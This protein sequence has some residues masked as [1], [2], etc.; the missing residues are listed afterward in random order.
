MLICVFISDSS[1]PGIAPKLEALKALYEGKKIIVGRD[2][3]DVVKGILQKVSKNASTID[4]TRA[5]IR[6]A[7]CVREAI[8]RLSR[9]DRQ[10]CDDPSNFSGF[11]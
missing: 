2:K 5:E 7:P 6:L 11:E 4:H 3:L 9:M 1:R 8:A 10:R